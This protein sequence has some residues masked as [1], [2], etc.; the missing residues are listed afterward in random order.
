MTEGRTRRVALLFL[1]V[2]ATACSAGGGEDSPRGG[3]ST[4]GERNAICAT[5]ESRGEVQAPVFVANLRGQTSW[6]AAPVV[7]DLDGDGSN[8]LIAAYYSVYVFDS[9]RQ[10]LADSDDGDE[11]RV[12]AP[13]VVV[14]LEG[15]GSKEIVVGRGHRVVA[16]SWSG[17]SSGLD[18]RWVADTT[19]AGNAPEVRGLAA[20]D[21][22]GDGLIEVVATTTQTASTESGGAQVFVFGADGR[23]YQPAG[24]HR[25]AWPRYNN[26]SGEGNDADRNLQGHSGFGCYGLNV[27]IGD[28][29]D[30]PELEVI[31]TYDNHHIQAFNHDG[32]AIDTAPWFSNRRSEFAGERLTWGQFIRWAD[33]QVE[34][35]HYHDQVGEWPHPSWAEWLQW[36]ASPPNVV[37]LDGDGDNEV[38]GV[39]NVEMHEPYETQA[40]ALMVLEGA[41]GDGSRSAMRLPGWESLPRGDRPILVDGWYPP[42]GVPAAAT[43]NLQGDARPEIIV[44][45]ND[46][47]LYAFGADAEVLW[48]FDYT[49]GRAVMYASEP[50]VADLNQDG[51][52]EVL[53]ATYGAPNVTDSG[54]LIVLAADGSSLHD[55]ALPDPGSNGN[56][57]GAPAA[58]SVGDLDGDGELEIFVQTFDH[59]MDVFRVPGSGVD[60]LP[61]ATARG[62][63]L[64]MGQPNGG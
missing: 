3:S 16:Y 19:T 54:R 60:C 26:L 44:S 43:V 18:R 56:G 64:R 41:Y 17:S 24:G 14:D 36:T 39:P 62:G 55:I 6:Y 28:I 7:A 42:G 23:S 11:G 32:V 38:L 31:A 49:H 51:S 52:P 20:A 63:P 29:D 59:G 4:G 9:E 58:P 53:F 5:G 22:D 1:F 40:Y 25:P 47:F 10:L 15:D 34:A 27:A 45:L 30:D 37:D 2:G 61:W 21:L 13:H 50:V 12:Y 48:R 8:E 35:D 33:P 46:G 57:N